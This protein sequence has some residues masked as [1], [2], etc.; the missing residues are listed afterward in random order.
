MVSW[1]TSWR[2]RKWIADFATDRY[3]VRVKL[4]IKRM[5]TG[6]ASYHKFDIARGQL[7]TA[8]RL[9]LQDGCDVFSA[10][11]LVRAA[12]ELLAAL[13]GRAGKKPFVDDIVQLE[14]NR[15]NRTPSRGAMDRHLNACFFVN[16]M[17][18]LDKGRDEIIEFDAEECATGAIPKA[19]AYYETL[20][21]EESAA[22]KA[23]SCRPPHW[24]AF[25]ISTCRTSVATISSRQMCRIRT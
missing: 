18:H 6:T 20:I 22:M 5:L 17:K 24:K 12:G 19:I 23:R 13:V 16:E 2:I 1:S 9:F 15:E 10:I 11:T 25:R 4:T 7:E 8:I 14:Q 21:G 3:D